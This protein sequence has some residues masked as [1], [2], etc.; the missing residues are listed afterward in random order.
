LQ[1]VYIRR[2]RGDLAAMTIFADSVLS[3]GLAL[4][5]HVEQHYGIRPQYLLGE[6]V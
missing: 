6:A 1:Q 3:V 5:R 4:I 2:E